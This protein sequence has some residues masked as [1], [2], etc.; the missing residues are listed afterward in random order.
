MC[1]G[2]NGAR[3]GMYGLSII[4]LVSLKDSRKLLPLCDIGE[5]AELGSRTYTET[6]QVMYAK[7]QR[8]R[9]PT[10]PYIYLCIV[11]LL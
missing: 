3:C 2:M 7:R 8:K 10:C 5:R 4:P 11:A 6:E 1:V 9:I